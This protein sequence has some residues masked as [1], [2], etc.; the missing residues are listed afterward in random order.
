MLLVLI[1]SSCANYRL[2]Y[3]DTPQA[4]TERD[5]EK[6]EQPEHTV[7]LIG[8]SGYSPKDGM[9]PALELLQTKLSRA[10][11]NSSVVFLGD[12]IYPVGLPP[13][14]KP[15]D[16]AVAEH[17]LDA[18]LEALQ[19]YP[20]KPI[21]L[22][23]N[24]D[25]SR[26][27][28]KGVRR[29]E[30]YIQK[31]L[32]AG[33]EDEDE[34]EK[35]FLPEDG[36]GGP[37][38][39][40][41][42]ERLVI[43]VVDTQWWLTNWDKQP[44]INDGC[45]AKSRKVFAFLFEEAVRKHRNKNIIIAV[46]HPVYTYGPHG[47]YF[48]PYQHLFPLA[49]IDDGLKIPLPV[50]G[51]VLAFLRG[52][53]GSKQ[54]IVHQEYK[55]LR[56][57]LLDAAKKN[58]Q[59]IF[60]SGHEHSLQYIERE[61]QFF[62]VS[63]NGSKSTPTR[64]GKGS[65]FSYGGSNGFA[66]ID[67]YADGSAWITYYAVDEE[68]QKP[69][70]KIVFQKKMK[71]ALSVDQSTPTFDFS[72]YRAQRDSVQAVSLLKKPVKRKG[73]FHKLT[74]GAHYRDLYAEGYDL[75]VLDLEEFR[76]GLTPIKRGGGN[77]TNS[78]RLRD[79]QGQQYVMRSMT[80]DASRFIPYP[81]N[82]ITPSEFIVEDNFLSTHP[83]AAIV[84][85]HLAEAVEV[86]HTNPTIYYV[87][88]QPALAEHNDVFGGEVYLVEERPAK[89]WSELA[90][91]GNSSK[92]ISTNDV[93]TKIFKNHKHK[94]DQNW[95]VRSRLLDL[96]IGDW[97]R[98]GDQWR[99]AMFED[100]EQKTYRPIPRD[101]DQPF[102]KYDGLLTKCIRVTVPFLKQLQVYD[103][104]VKNI[105]WVTYGARS[106]DRTFLNALSWEEWEA[107]AKFIQENLTDE[108][109]ENA[110][111]VL[112][113]YAYENSGIRLIEIVK[114]RRNDLLKTARRHYDFVSK[115]VDVYG[116][117]KKELFEVKRMDDERTRVRVYQLKKGEKFKKV[118][119]RIFLRS[120]TEEIRL[121]G[122]GGEDRFEISGKVNK[123]I[124]IRAVG[125]LDD[126]VFVDRS[127]VKGRSKKTLIYDAEEGNTIQSSA[128]T[129]D[130][131][132]ESRELNIY[133]NRDYHY[134]YDFVLPT[135]LASYNPDDGVSLGAQFIFTDYRYKKSPYG[136]KHTVRGQYAF[137]TSA[138]N[139]GYDGEFIGV[140]GK[141]DF[142]LSARFQAPMF[143]VNYFGS[144]N[145]TVNN[146][147]NFDFNRVRQSLWQIHPAWRKRFGGNNGSLTIGA[148]AER[149]EIERTPDRFLFFEE[150]L[151]EQAFE[152]KFFAGST[153]NFSYENVNDAQMPTRG[154][155]FRLGS[156]FKWNVED[157]ERFLVPFRTEMTIYQ[158]LTDNE[159]LILASR[160]GT[161]HIFGDFEFFQSAIIGGN[162]NL[163]GYRADRFY[164][165]TSFYHNNDLRLRLFRTEN[166]VIPFSFGITGGF[167]YGRVWLDDESSDTWHY[168]YG[169]GLWI[170]PVDFLVLHS[171]LFLSEEDRRFTFRVGYTF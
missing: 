122:L 141:A 82:K 124:L 148:L 61:G 71:D 90:S 45:E 19:G 6:G 130:L 10:G 151:T 7:F 87:P 5:T 114:K 97:D 146:A 135:P 96:V 16:R 22:P 94:I 110:F 157:T 166:G 49:E 160:I 38:V 156:E 111:R 143:T 155:R 98:H 127:K 159:G 154:I 4:W 11:A 163:R 57:T 99:W 53:I 47:G 100:G 72:E 15:E 59:F 107:E 83:F 79:P 108:A 144:G 77:Q 120:E 3:R 76:G 113:D 78:L 9:A 36:C 75:P 170:A 169:G 158:N 138:Y 73:G 33:I 65:E 35:Y 8:D 31:K 119:E 89:D 55:N 129:K 32:N 70:G 91:F 66:K 81:F 84:V 162:S 139:I 20:G 54:D 56:K 164:G 1:S 134:E 150:L 140:L 112:P 118:Y 41:I 12:N 44:E 68:G 92:I 42:N 48:T 28:L 145:E 37:E 123:G 40:E 17:R 39:V 152:A 62:I 24:H 2:N 27:G 25:W 46:H 23:G 43:I 116:T 14:S 106:F 29:Q 95:T 137:A 63:G 34:W 125:G 50:L 149:I 105:K 128:E 93:T 165:R 153:L 121:Y 26:Y 126:D 109:I 69:E 80:K 86:Y 18:Q 58:G 103:Q 131:T 136:A 21:F 115:A 102:A 168:G 101:R 88:K 161:Q 104:N 117:E 51:S 167:D 64:L 52:T 67:F 147:D 133:N 74:L 132:S 60:A 13:K 142:V 30:K 171:E 85:P